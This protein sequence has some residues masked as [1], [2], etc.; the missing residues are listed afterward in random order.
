LQVIAGRPDTG[1]EDVGPIGSKEFEFLLR[2]KRE[3][4]VEAGGVDL[5][6]VE[7]FMGIKGLREVSVRALVERCARPV[8]EKLAFWV[9]FSRSVV[10]GG[11]G[12]WVT[13]EMVGEGCV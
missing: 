9:A 13:G 4:K 12:E 5:E 6:W 1:F 3:W 7:Q 10:E 11:F 2:M 8:S